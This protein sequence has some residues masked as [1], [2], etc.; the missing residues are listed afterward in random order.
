[1]TTFENCYLLSLL[2]VAE[3]NEELKKPEIADNPEKS[4]AARRKH[5]QQ[6]IR[7]IERGLTLIRP[8]DPLKEVLDARIMLVYAHLVVGNN[9]QTAVLASTWPKA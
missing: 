3:L 4:K 1:V 7:A 5:Y 9:Y 6:V 2:E 8:T